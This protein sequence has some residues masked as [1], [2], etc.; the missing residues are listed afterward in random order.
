MFVQN[1]FARNTFG[2]FDMF[3]P[4]IQIVYHAPITPI[5]WTE[6]GDWID[7]RSAEDIDLKKGEFALINLGVSMKLPDG[8]EAHVAPRSST[9]KNFKIIQTNSVAVIDN[10]YS[11][12]NDIWKYPV[13][14]MEDTHISFDDRICQFRLMPVM[15]KVLFQ[16]E[17]TLDETDRGGIGSTGVK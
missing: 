8:Y 1:N 14:A 4:I 11:G 9:Y 5:E 17:E 13:L 16:V 12:T 6:K 10:N 15:G 2:G 3:Y 7:L